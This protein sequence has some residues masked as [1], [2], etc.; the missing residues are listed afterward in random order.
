MLMMG[1]S[2]LRGV[3]VSHPDC[4]ALPSKQLLQI[5][6]VDMGQPRSQEA[7]KSARSS[8]VGSDMEN[9]SNAWSP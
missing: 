4:S 3:A 7:N 5:R 8:Q 1:K 9:T 2:G 6:A